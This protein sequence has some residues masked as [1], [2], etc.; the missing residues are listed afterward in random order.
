MHGA[1]PV[2]HE[3]PVVAHV[4]VVP[5][6]VQPLEVE[7]LGERLAIVAREDGVGDLRLGH[8]ALPG[9]F[10][11]Q[12]EARAHQAPGDAVATV[13]RVHADVEYF[14]RTLDVVRLVYVHAGF[15]LRQRNLKV[16]SNVNLFLSIFLTRG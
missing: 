4:L 7:L 16:G 12:L 8:A 5:L 13:A 2:G 14:H 9:D 11:R 1:D 10:T 6:R 15:D 3:F